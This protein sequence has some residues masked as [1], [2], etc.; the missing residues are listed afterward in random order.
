MSLDRQHNGFIKISAKNDPD[1]STTIFKA[2]LSQV[3]WKVD[4]VMRVA[5]KAGMMAKVMMMKSD[6]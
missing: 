2:L 6:A 4:D 3:G 5:K 1:V